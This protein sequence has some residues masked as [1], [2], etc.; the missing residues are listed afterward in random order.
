[1]KR[2]FRLL[3]VAIGGL[4]IIASDASAKDEKLKP[5]ELVARHLAA[6]GSVEA[7]S[8]V[9][10]RALAGTTTFVLRLGGH[11][12]GSGPANVLSDERRMRMGLKYTSLQVPGEQFAFDGKGVSVGL[13]RPGERS[14]LSQFVH[15]Y[16]VMLRDGLLG[17]VLSAAWGLLDVTGRQ[18]KLTSTGVKKI[19]GRRLHEL[20]YQDRQGTTDLQIS[21]YF[22][23]E[24]FRHVLTQYRLAQPSGMPSAPGETPPRDTFH[25]VKESFDDF[26]EV[27][28][29]IL[30]HSYKLVYTI[31]GLNTTY[32]GQWSI[33]DIKIVHNIP[34]ED[35][36]FSIK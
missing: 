9:K 25:T 11:G 33:F 23:P 6:I 10:S 31:E 13:I 34:M 24:T 17:G 7:R 2:T 18:P 12:E 29:L 3:A 19:E 26:K 5:E 35:A 15:H 32:I 4:T 27:D 1:M 14:P 16:E 20:K 28:G 36:Y 30:P 8:R 22:D 21:L